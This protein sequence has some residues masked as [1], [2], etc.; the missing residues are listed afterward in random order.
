MN[1][2]TEEG[3]VSTQ[4]SSADLKQIAVDVVRQAMQGGATAA[5]AVAVDGS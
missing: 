3:A 2:S 1:V 4:V 5:E